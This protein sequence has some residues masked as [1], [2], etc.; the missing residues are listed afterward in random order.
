MRSCS[1]FQLLF[2]H[3]MALAVFGRNVQD[4]AVP[5]LLERFIEKVLDTYYGVP[6]FYPLSDGP[7]L[8]SMFGTKH[9]P[10]RHATNCVSRHAPPAERTPTAAS[11]VEWLQDYHDDGPP[12]RFDHLAF[13]TF[14]VRV[15]FW[16]LH[17]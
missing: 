2:R 13:R 8:G 17:F 7:T 16:L 3:G 4:G 10:A 1:A 14:G 9:R 5:P 6:S 12:I 15:L 11:I